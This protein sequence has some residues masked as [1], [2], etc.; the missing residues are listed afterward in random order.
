MIEKQNSCKI[1]QSKRK[2]ARGRNRWGFIP[3][4]NFLQEVKIQETK[5]QEIMHQNAS[6]LY[7]QYPIAIRH[8]SVFS[9]QHHK[10]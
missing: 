3:V 7:R 2:R 10:I 1:I 9:I 5:C 8:K 4:T 6:V